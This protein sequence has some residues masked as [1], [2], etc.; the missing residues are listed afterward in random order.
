MTGD[1]SYEKILY[2]DS[3]RKVKV[4]NMCEVVERLRSEGQIKY[5]SKLWNFCFWQTY[6]T[7][8]CESPGPDFHMFRHYSVIYAGKVELVFLDLTPKFYS[9]VHNFLVTSNISRI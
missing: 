6:Q 2:D 7:G 9:V 1:S 3:N 8:T 4:K 5:Y